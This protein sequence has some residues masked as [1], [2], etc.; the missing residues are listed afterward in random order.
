MK[1]KNMIFLGI[2]MVACCLFFPL[3]FTGGAIT[4]LGAYFQSTW[5]LAAG[6]LIIVLAIIFFQRK[7]EKS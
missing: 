3:L 5:L 2:A 1:E 4:F 7:K 6:L